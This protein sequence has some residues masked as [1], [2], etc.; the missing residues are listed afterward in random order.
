MLHQAARK[1]PVR[2]SPAAK[3]ARRTIMMKYAQCIRG[4][5]DRRRPRAADIEAGF[6]FSPSTLLGILN[7]VGRQTGLGRAS[8]PST[9]NAKAA[10]GSWGRGWV[11]RRIIRLWPAIRVRSTSN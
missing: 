4:H 3:S 8:G 5:S 7:A 1:E 10:R 2:S 11:R 9:G 6:G